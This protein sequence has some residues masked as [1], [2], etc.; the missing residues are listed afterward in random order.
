MHCHQDVACASRYVITAIVLERSVWPGS[1]NG[2]P[3][4][5]DVRTR[6]QSS[7]MSRGVHPLLPGVRRFLD[8]GSTRCRSI[9]GLPMV[10]P[11]HTPV[12]RCSHASP[13]LCDVSRSDSLAPWSQTFSGW[14][15][16]AAPLDPGA[17]VGRPRPHD[18][19]RRFSRPVRGLPGE[20]GE[21]TLVDCAIFGAG[22]GGLLRGG[23]R[24]AGVDASRYG[25]KSYCD[26]G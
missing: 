26:E 20:G 9:R 19:L 24:R 21:G 13:V 6:V 14:H 5:F 17:P 23:R 22:A 4:S 8:G 16:H 25:V 11:G 3:R 7:A 18:V 1:T 10:D 2:S 12:F 15:Q